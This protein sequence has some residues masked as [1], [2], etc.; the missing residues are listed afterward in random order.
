[1]LAFIPG[2]DALALNL[3]FVL[4]NYLRVQKLEK[5]FL[6]LLLID[7]RDFKIIWRS[8]GQFSLIA[9]NLLVL[10]GN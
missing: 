1:M 9:A 5:L 8:F 7:Q 6:E 10:F 3:L 2:I 4:V